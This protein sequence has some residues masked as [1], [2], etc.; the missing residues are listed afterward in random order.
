M[1]CYFS[2][3]FCNPMAP[4]I[5]ALFLIVDGV[6]ASARHGRQNRGPLFAHGVCV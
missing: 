4:M 1:F 5:Y 3:S 2:D 6:L